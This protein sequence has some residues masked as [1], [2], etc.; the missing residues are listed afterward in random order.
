MSK[1]A[2]HCAL[3][4]AA[5][6]VQPSLAAPNVDNECMHNALQSVTLE[7]RVKKVR[8]AFR[9][10]FSTKTWNCPADAKALRCWQRTGTDNGNDWEYAV[11]RERAICHRGD[12]RT[13]VFVYEKIDGA[14]HN[15]LSQ[16]VHGRTYSVEYL[17]LALELMTADG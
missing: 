10:H 11:I 14:E 7:H 16:R 5:F 15:D 8:R 4:V 3:A 1:N 17:T 6:A 9:S 12:F 2:F 13:F